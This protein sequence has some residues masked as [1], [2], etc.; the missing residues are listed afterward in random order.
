MNESFVWLLSV[1][2]CEVCGGTQRG[3]SG[4]GGLP[5]SEPRQQKQQKT[6]L[7]ADKDSQRVMM[8]QFS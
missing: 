1:M 6:M 8:G 4:G 2:S 7:I 5:N 3:D